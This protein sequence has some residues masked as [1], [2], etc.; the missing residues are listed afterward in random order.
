MKNRKN[1][2]L[3]IDDH[4]MNSDAYI[5]LIRSKE[6]F[7]ETIFHKGIDC[8]TAF[9]LIKQAE[10]TDTPFDVALIDI[11]IP[12]YR[13]QKLLSGTDVAILIRNTFP[14]CIIIML[15]MHNESLVLFNAY[16]QVSPEGFISKNDIDFEMFPEIFDRIVNVENYFSPSINNAIQQLLK[17][18]LSWDEFDTQ[19]LL[20]LEKGIQ[21]KDLK[22]Y[23]N[24]SQSTIEKR[25]VALKT[26]IFNQKVSDK[27][28]I[29]KCKVLK[30]I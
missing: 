11:S 4:P 30:L 29:E 25:K 9:K 10:I 21:T 1:N 26:Q 14:D 15:T 2:I 23:I 3:V 13:E 24:I 22:H 27:V 6:E 17:K 5:N 20:F 18:N 8:Q 19:I 28:L 7:N 12:E 16:K